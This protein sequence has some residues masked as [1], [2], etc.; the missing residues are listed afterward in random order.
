M[1]LMRKM[2]HLVQLVKYKK[3]EYV[4]VLP[5]K[6]LNTCTLLQ[7]QDSI[8]LLSQVRGFLYKSTNFLQLYCPLNTTSVFDI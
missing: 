5:L 6:G 7:F 2:L 3:S 1:A 8:E 4:H